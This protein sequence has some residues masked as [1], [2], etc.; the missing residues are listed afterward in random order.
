MELKTHM[1]APTLTVIENRKKL[2]GITSDIMRL[3]LTNFFANLK[4]FVT[5]GRTG[6]SGTVLV[7]FTPSLGRIFPILLYHY[8]RSF[9]KTRR[10]GVTAALQTADG[11]FLRVIFFQSSFQRLMMV[12]CGS[13]GNGLPKKSVRILPECTFG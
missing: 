11:P 6:C 12:L 4:R 2:D 3:C 8:L 9:G 7:K 13:K 10:Q 5:T 1:I